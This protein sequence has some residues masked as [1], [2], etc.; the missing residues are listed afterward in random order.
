M[1][2]PLKAGNLNLYR[3]SDLI[4]FIEE[5][6]QEAAQKRANRKAENTPS[7]DTPQLNG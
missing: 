2:T 3:K 4:R 5:C 6:G 7:K 1:I